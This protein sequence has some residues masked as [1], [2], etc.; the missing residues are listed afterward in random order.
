MTSRELSIHSTS[1]D[2]TLWRTV[3]PALE[4]G[5]TAYAVERRGR[6]EGG[7]SNRC[8][9]ERE[10]EDTASVVNSIPE[11][12]NV[13]GH[14]YGAVCSLEASL[15]TSKIRKLIL[16]EPPIAVGW[17]IVSVRVSWCRGVYIHKSTPI[18][19][20]VAFGDSLSACLVFATFSE[21]GSDDKKYP[22]KWSE[23]GCC[24]T[25]LSGVFQ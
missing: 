15:L 22:N 23:I 18:R 6:G 5:L 11:P 2:Q 13:L 21:H 9:I 16:Q 24:T 4:E 8:A 10:F 20:T 19:T 12:V 3:S 25:S 1:V 14:S 7:D 17:R